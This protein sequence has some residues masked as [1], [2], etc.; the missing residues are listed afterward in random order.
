VKTKEQESDFKLKVL[1]KMGAWIEV[2]C[3]DK[4]DSKDLKV[5][6]KLADF[7]IGVATDDGFSQSDL[8]R[9]LPELAK[10][11]EEI[12]KSRGKMVVKG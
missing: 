2:N 4:I 11:V 9:L 8:A 5:M 10:E 6:N 12:V 1:R 7:I 3:K